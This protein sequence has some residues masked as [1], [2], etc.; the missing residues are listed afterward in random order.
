MMH[1][2]R[3]LRIVSSLAVVVFLWGCEDTSSPD[4]TMFPLANAPENVVAPDS[5]PAM[6]MKGPKHRFGRGGPMVMAIKKHSDELGLSEDQMASI[7]SIMEKARPEA[8]PEKGQFKARMEE[9]HGLI[10]AET[11]DED[12]FTA[13]HDEMQARF[14]EMK[15]KQ[16]SAF[17]D[18]LEVLSAEQRTGLFAIMKEHKGE[19]GHFKGK[20]GH[21]GP[22]GMLLKAIRKMGDEL[23]Q[24]DEQKQAIEA[25]VKGSREEMK[26]L[27]DQKKALRLQMHELMAAPQLDR[28]AIEAKH[29]EILDLTQEKETKRLAVTLEALKILTVDQRVKFV[30]TLEQCRPGGCADGDCPC[31]EIFGH[32]KG[33]S[34]DMKDKGFHKKGKGLHKKPPM[35]GEYMGSW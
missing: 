12:A 29:A 4:K 7:D 10:K 15:V 26:P 20:K 13:R 8:P 28:A 34:F 18:A 27:K 14:R 19:K 21:K 22:H 1:S 17:L 33:K 30:S 6:A 31:K 35:G 32:K 9:M 23:E 2:N 25:L 11:I 3:T 24:T 16:F 5:D